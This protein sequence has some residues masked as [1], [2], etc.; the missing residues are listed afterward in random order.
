MAI[1]KARLFD[2]LSVHR[3][4]EELASEWGD[5][6]SH[7]LLHLAG[8]LEADNGQSD[9]RGIAFYYRHRMDADRYHPLKIPVSMSMLIHVLHLT[10]KDDSR[11]M[12][13]SGLTVLVD[14][15][16]LKNLSIAQRTFEP[17]PTIPSGKM[18]IKISFSEIFVNKSDIESLL[19]GNNLPVPQDWREMVVLGGGF[20]KS[21]QSK[22]G[23]KPKWDTGM[24]DFINW[25][26]SEIGADG[27]LFTLSTVKRWLENNALEY[28]HQ[29]MDISDCEDVYFADGRIGWINCK[30]IPKS[31]ALRSLDRYIRRAKT[32]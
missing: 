3:L 14:E 4:V 9:D 20:P 18:S 19:L 29:V 24:Q 2:E 10:A 32:A 26:H 8:L 6:E 21:S 12:E 23:K 15:L 17:P 7:V 1:A 22:G 16:R 25:L 13:D 11:R 27:T 28:T 5:D 30:G 31:L